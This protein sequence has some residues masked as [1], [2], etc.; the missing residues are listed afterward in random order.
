MNRLLW[1]LVAP[2]LGLG[3]AGGDLFCNLHDR[4]G[5]LLFRFTR[6]FP[7]DVS[8]VQRIIVFNADNVRDIVLS[9]PALKALRDKFPLARID[10]LVEATH[11]A[12]LNCYEGWST[13][14]TVANI[15]DGGEI[16]MLGRKLQTEHYDIAIVQHASAYGFRLAYASRA[17]VRIGWKAKG[18]GYL[19][20]HGL[21]ESPP[22]THQHQVENILRLY[23]PLG[24]SEPQPRF[25]FKLTAK[26]ESQTTQFLVHHNLGRRTPFVAVHP[27]SDSPRSQWFAE[28]YAGLIDIIMD[29]GFPVVMIGNGD[30]RVMTERVAALCRTKPLM[31]MEAFD[32]EGLACFLNRAA[33]FVGNCSGPMHIAASAGIWTIAIFGDRHMMARI[34]QWRPYAPK[35]IVVKAECT[36][37]PCIPWTCKQRTCERDFTVDL[38]WEKIRPILMQPGA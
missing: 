26:G 18:Y 24:I 38:V 13:I 23:A 14:H 36:K 2:L 35:G 22:L 34:E 32:L 28:R 3:R 4:G 8:S 27:A 21:C 5:R 6:D 17:P 1:P 31:A 10:C 20:T 16:R 37:D 15:R 11:A 12:L 19:L 29:N 7:I 25:P 9:M 33:V 30:D